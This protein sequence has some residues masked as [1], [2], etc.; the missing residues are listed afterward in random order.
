MRMMIRKTETWCMV[1]GNDDPHCRVVTPRLDLGHILH[2][3]VVHCRALR[4][5]LLE[6]RDSV[7]ELSGIIGTSHP[8]EMSYSQDSLILFTT[9][10]VIFVFFYHFMYTYVDKLVNFDS[11]WFYTANSNNALDT[12]HLYFM[13]CACFIIFRDYIIRK[14]ER[15]LPSKW[16]W[17]TFK[18]HE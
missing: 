9:D 1:P 4:L 6:Q 12:T 8:G 15:Q 18:I 14:L 3:L 17:K 5:L 13:W 10:F 16:F 7:F 11:S 2:D